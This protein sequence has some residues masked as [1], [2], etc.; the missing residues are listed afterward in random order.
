VG[1]S[2]FMC[3]SFSIFPKIYFLK[4]MMINKVILVGLLVILFLVLIQPYVVGRGEGFVED[5]NMCPT[6]LKSSQLQLEATSR[7]LMSC[8]GDKVN[9]QVDLN[10]KLNTCLNDK[11]IQQQRIDSKMQEISNSKEDI[12]TEKQRYVD[13]QRLYEKEKQEKTELLDKIGKINQESSVF[14]QQVIE[15][16][17][18]L[19]KC[20]SN[21]S[22]ITSKSSNIQQ[23]NK[24]M[25]VLNQKLLKDYDELNR[26]YNIYCY[27]YNISLKKNQKPRSDPV[28]SQQAK[29]P[30][31][32]GQKSKI[33]EFGS[34]HG[35]S[36]TDLSMTD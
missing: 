26:K 11:I 24:D 31:A 12:V 17:K 18:Q 34:A 7:D 19:E 6:N 22:N 32:S 14:T 21:M 15:L 28:A 4:L 3:I 16:Q 9:I 5:I 1:G 8:K 25:I 10:E 23:G 35:V 2:G 29:A 13:L 30:S 27:E 33:N 20:N 36:A